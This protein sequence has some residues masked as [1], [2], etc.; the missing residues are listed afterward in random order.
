MSINAPVGHLP[1]D[2]TS[3]IS[4]TGLHGAAEGLAV[5]QASQSCNALT[6]VVADNTRRLRILA[7]EIAFFIGSDSTVPIIQFP[8]WE[9]L[10]YDTVSPHPDITSER[11]RTLTRLTGI[12]K[13]ILLLTVGTLSQRLPPPDYVL[14]QSFVLSSGTNV[15]NASLRKQLLTAGYVPVSQ[16]TYP[17]EYAVRGGVIDIYPMGSD[18][19]FRLDFFGDQIERIRFFSPE[20]QKSTRSTDSIE[21]LPGREYPTSDDA[22][23]LF[24]SNF[25]KLF[26]GDPQK[27]L[28]YRALSERRLPT[29]LDYFWPL[30]FDKHATL[31]DYLDDQSL[32]ILDADHRDSITS[33]WAVIQDRY[34]L[35][36]MIPERM[37]L[38]PKLLFADPIE[39]QR[40]L[41]SYKVISFLNDPRPDSIPA[42]D[43]N[44]RLPETFPVDIRNPEPFAP[45]LSHV[46]EF[47]GR[48][49]LAISSPGRSET[50]NDVLESNGIDVRR[51]T[52]WANFLEVN[53]TQIA[54]VVA[55]LE[56]GAI[57]Y[58]EAIEIISEDQIFGARK[59]S[60]RHSSKRRRDPEKIIQ[61]LAELQL[62]DAIVHEDHG[63]GRYRGL[64]VLGILETENE[65]LVI[66]Y[67]DG[68]KLYVPVL[69]LHIVSRYL[70]G[71]PET[72]PIHKLGGDTWRLARERAKEQTR[73]V[74]AELL[75]TQSIR[76]SRKGHS[77][78]VSPEDYSSFVSRFPY[79]ETEDQKDVMEEV[80]QDLESE[81]PMDRLVCGDVGFGKTEIALR[82]AFVAIDNSRQV[83]M[84]VPTTLLAQ[85]HYHTFCDRFAHLPVMIEL[86][87]RFRSR[88]ETKTVIEQLHEGAVDIVIGTHRL[89]Q[90]DVRFR[91]VGLLIIDEE[92]RFGVRQKERL[93]QLRETVD[94]L[95]LTATPIPRTLNVGM[96]GLRDISLIATA[97]GERIAI[98]TSVR[99]SHG[100]LVREACLREIQRGGQ[101]YFL[102]NEV[103]TI[104][105]AAR[106]LGE[107]LPEAIIDVA[108]GQMP[109]RELNMV[110]QDFY[111]HRSDV[112]VCSTI[113]ENGIDVPN[114]NTII[115]NRADRFGLAQLHQLRGRVG[116]SHR[117]AY[118]Y[119]L[120]PSLDDLT[121][122]A[123]KRLEAIE[124]LVDLGAGFTLA[125]HDLEI[126]GAGEL[127][128]E[129]QSGTIDEIGFTLYAD[130]LKRAIGEASKSSVPASSQDVSPTVTPEIDL[131]LPALFPDHYIPDVHTRLVLY[132][133]IGGAQDLE[134]LYDLQLETIDRFGLLPIPS[135][136]LFGISKLKIKAARLGVC[137]IV[138][139]AKSGKIVFSPDTPVNPVHIVCLINQN[140]EQIKMTGS[141]ELVISV[142]LPDA[143]GRISFIEDLLDKLTID[144]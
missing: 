119:L 73:D 130:Y 141:S 138:L 29:G 126:R 70:G 76:F 122:N 139:N 98:Q 2:R 64:Q 92:Q 14:G 104:E 127:L 78:H 19:P 22:I 47:Q 120:V 36:A 39:I 89:L 33:N 17:G 105:S 69:N 32:W 5:A 65:F 11:L 107:L 110:M 97:P 71:D 88:I 118:A 93:K 4:W 136:T 125:S 54:S 74:A 131:N 26:E 80:L 87:S 128:G 133:R 83:V 46:E 51:V 90:D 34:P 59:K 48:L 28:I 35:A 38:E 9:C 84:L 114:A 56:R 143:E 102:H 49:I 86:L 121:G 77:F 75:Q 100:A 82:A 13:G 3:P 45:L 44:T 58:D 8:D 106:R 24:R 1:I 101:V 115:I 41:S 15:D 63:I 91:D 30:F 40:E 135:K 132:K 10:P 111:G 16:V 85:Q 129:Q 123:R 61:S 137:K 79:E 95:T 23:S 113:I 81:M 112:L 7:D 124:S 53:N 116:R 117:Q 108:H 67:K 43:Y 62:N 6:V 31:F 66:E 18:Q 140:S 142:K 27:H 72:A 55:P 25:R 21:L 37:P 12:K 144:S 50:I 103:R 57:L 60:R 42:V 99:E 109:E 134:G 68:D 96:A 20:T 52:C 94:I